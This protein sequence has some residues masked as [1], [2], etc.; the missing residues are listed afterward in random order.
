MY[1]D[2]SYWMKS[3]FI[4]IIHECELLLYYKFKYSESYL[5]PYTFIRFSS[6]LSFPYFSDSLYHLLNFFLQVSRHLSIHQ[7]ADSFTDLSVIFPTI[8]ECNCQLPKK[9]GKKEGN[10]PFADGLQTLH[11]IAIL[12]LILIPRSRCI[13]SLSLPSWQLA[14]FVGS[15]QSYP[16]CW[17]R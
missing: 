15:C 11:G 12:I 14:K 2:L 13:R 3:E 10:K 16:S 8:V 7:Y 17:P 9:E 1:R 4:R 6:V 5:L